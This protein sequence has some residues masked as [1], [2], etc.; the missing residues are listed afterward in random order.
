MEDQ[1]QNVIFYKGFD[2]PTLA[3]GLMA[4]LK[5]YAGKEPC[6]EHINYRTF[7]DGEIDDIFADRERIAGKTIV[8]FECLKNE[9]TM[10]RFLQLCWAA[11]YQYG[12]RHIIAAISFLHYRRQD[13]PE[14]T[15]EIHRNR[16]LIEMMKHNGVDHLI[17][18]TPHSQQTER[19]CA[20]VGIAFRAVDPS[21]AFAS[22]LRPLLPENCDKEKAKIYA[23]D[24][25]SIPRAIALA[26]H[27]GVGVIFNLK[28]RGI[29]NKTEMIDAD[30]AM[31]DAIKKKYADHDIV[32]AT[33][34]CVKDVHVVMIED[35]ADTGGTANTQASTLMGYGARVVLACFTHPVCSDGWKR[36]LFAQDPFAKIIMCDTIT[37]GTEQ[38]T[39]GMVHDISM[40]GLLASSV[41][42][43]LRKNMCT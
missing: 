24:E 22:I 12:A 26:K 13:R 3:D 36:K 18:V 31:I 15:D 42:R 10:L 34:E 29:N 28:H 14:K 39:G 8:F 16:W 5:E 7:V 27:L 9:R 33:P 21:E 1:W 6:V 11:K 19:N 23:P 25:G 4:K 40:A 38:R 30:R 32:Y 20:D 41:Y 37:R 2:N 35:E 43:V 17:V